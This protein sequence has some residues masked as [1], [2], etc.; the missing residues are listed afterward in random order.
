MVYVNSKGQRNQ[1][2]ITAAPEKGF[3]V[4]KKASV[5]W[6]LGGPVSNIVRQLL[7]K[8]GIQAYVDIRA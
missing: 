6:V 3:Q 1:A 4:L 8:S 7:G 2:G 5:Y